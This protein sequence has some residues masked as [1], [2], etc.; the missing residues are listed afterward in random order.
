MRVDSD[1]RIHVARSDSALIDIFSSNGTRIGT[2]AM[3]RQELSIT[4]SELE[5][6]VEALGEDFGPLLRQSP[7]GTWPIIENFFLEDGGDI[8]WGFTTRTGQPTEWIVTD[9]NGTE[10]AHV[11]LP[12]DVELHLVRAGLAYGVIH[13]EY[14]VPRIAI[15]EVRKLDGS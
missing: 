12:E 15:Y 7:P 11:A 14:E 8:W 13:D 6:A 1:D 3:N 5:H 2:V 4:R 10:R 9:P